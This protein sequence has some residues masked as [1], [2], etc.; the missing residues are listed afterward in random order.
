MGLF[1]KSKRLVC[2]V[3]SVP[4]CDFKRVAMQFCWGHTSA[5]VFCEFAM[6]FQDTSLEG[7]VNLF[8]AKALLS[9]IVQFKGTLTVLSM[10]HRFLIFYIFY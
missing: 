5:W 9:L 2:G 7:N 8:F 10:T 6:Y 4:K 3:V 1:T